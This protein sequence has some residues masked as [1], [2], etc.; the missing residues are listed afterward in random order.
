VVA[1]LLAIPTGSDTKL[2]AP[3]G[4]MVYGRD[5]FGGDDRVPLDDQA[6]AA[7]DTKRRCGLSGS[8]QRDEQVI[9]VAV[10]TRQLP[11]AGPRAL[12]AGRDMRVLGEEQRLVAVLLNQASNGSR[13]EGVVRREV[14][15]SEIDAASLV[16]RRALRRAFSDRSWRSQK[17]RRAQRATPPSLVTIGTF[18]RL[19]LDR[20]VLFGYSLRL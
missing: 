6:D 7:A 8:R 2:K 10:F 18:L 14:S 3:A 5:L 17:G 19:F 15:D 1:H 4:E 16:S 11:A 9:G 12:A 20:R 13:S